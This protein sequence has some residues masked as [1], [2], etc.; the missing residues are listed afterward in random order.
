MVAT[1]VLVSFEC[2]I[3]LASQASFH[4]FLLHIVFQIKPIVGFREEYYGAFCTTMARKGPIMTF[5]QE[6]ISK[7][8]FWN[9]KPILLI[10]Q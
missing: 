9:I 2:S 5:L 7:P 10:P 1:I 6:H 8:P 3:L 4:I